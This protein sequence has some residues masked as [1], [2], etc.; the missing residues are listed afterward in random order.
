MKS[1]KVFLIW[2]L[3][4]ITAE[5]EQV[6]LVPS[7]D[8]A[9]KRGGKSIPVYKLDARPKYAD[10]GYSRLVVYYDKSAF[11]QE[12]IE[13]YD[14]AGKHLKTRDSSAWKPT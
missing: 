14:K 5:A 12:R 6:T 2:L 10:T 1:R 7:A 13:Y 9:L 4:V 11:R 8:T 3:C